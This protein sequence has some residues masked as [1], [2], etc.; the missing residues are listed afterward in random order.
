MRRRDRYGDA[1]NDAPWNDGL[2]FREW[3]GFD[4]LESRRRR[5]CS[6]QILRIPIAPT[7]AAETYTTRRRLG[8]HQRRHLAL[9]ETKGGGV[10]ADQSSISHFSAGEQLCRAAR[11]EHD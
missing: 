7:F 11:W 1:P 8:A 3:I 2:R 6:P 4:E 5:E 10:S 9:R